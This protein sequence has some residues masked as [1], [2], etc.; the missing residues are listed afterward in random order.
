M[1]QKYQLFC[2]QNKQLLALILTLN[3]FIFEL[4][5]LPSNQIMGTICISYIQ[6]H[7]HVW[8]RREIHLFSHKT[9]IQQ[10]SALHR[11][12]FYGMDQIREPIKPFINE[13]NKKHHSIKPDLKFSKEKIEFWDILIYQDHNNRSQTTL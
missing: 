9:Q 1:Y 7:I 10:L 12:Y 13:I 3:N 4:K 11:R 8:V 2:K 5:V 6:N